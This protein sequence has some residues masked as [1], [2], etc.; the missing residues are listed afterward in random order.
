MYHPRTAHGQEHEEK[1]LVSM[2]GFSKDVE[3]RSAATQLPEKP[4]ALPYDLRTEMT[5]LDFCNPVNPLGTPKPFVQAMHTALVDGE[6]N[7]TPIAT[8]A[9]SAPP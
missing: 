5:W 9:R 6:L 8:A 1:G 7:Y 2:L 3:Y 4:V